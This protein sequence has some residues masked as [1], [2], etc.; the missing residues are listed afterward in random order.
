M[1]LE[2]PLVFLDTETTGLDPTV[3]EVVELAYSFHD[4][5]N[6]RT[7][8]VPHTLVHAD[9][10]ALRINRYRERGLEYRSIWATPDEF[11]QMRHDLSGATICSANVVFDLGFIDKWISLDRHYRVMD[12]TSWAAGRLGWPVTRGMENTYQE[13][14]RR[15]PGIEA[16]THTAAGDVRAMKAMY[17][18][19]LEV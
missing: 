19:L 14:R 9:P 6:V 18:A 11:E 8:V 15:F 4:D 7:M 13:C 16:P 2:R 17:L 3:H 5:P 12:F 1:E 10:E